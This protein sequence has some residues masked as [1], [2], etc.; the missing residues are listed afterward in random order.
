MQQYSCYVNCP[1]CGHIVEIVCPC[2]GRQIEMVRVFGE[3]EETGTIGYH[4]KSR[5]VCPDCR[6][7]MIAYWSLA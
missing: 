4:Q 7:R 3:N 6:E 2:P 5:A 1:N